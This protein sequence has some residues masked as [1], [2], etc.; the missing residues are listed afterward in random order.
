MMFLFVNNVFAI[1]YFR[2]RDFYIRGSNQ[3]CNCTLLLSCHPMSSKECN[4][5]RKSTTAETLSVP[6]N[7]NLE[8]PPSLE[9]YRIK[10]PQQKLWKNKTNE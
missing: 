3:V 6:T 9:C 10:N 4:K 8:I 1:V 7:T 5:R 2:F